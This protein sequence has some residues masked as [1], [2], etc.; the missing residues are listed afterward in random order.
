MQT[1]QAAV[2]VDPLELETQHAELARRTRELT[3]AIRRGDADLARHLDFLHEYAVAHFGAEEEQML[4]AGYPG[5]VRHQAEHDRFVGDLLALG[6]AYEQK[7]RAA[8]QQL[9]AE[10]WL[11]TWLERHVGGTDAELARWLS[12]RR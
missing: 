6:D 3:Q 8:F 5:T 12:G 2:A 4:A 7:G 1:S 9:N 10:A 11:T